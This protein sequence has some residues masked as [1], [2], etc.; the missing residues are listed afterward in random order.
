[1]TDASLEARWL[2]ERSAAV[3]CIFVFVSDSFGGWGATCSYS[4]VCLPKSREGRTLSVAAHGAGYGGGGEK[5]KLVQIVRKCN[6]Y[7]INDRTK[8]TP[9]LLMYA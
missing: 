2:T 9:L 4:F 7:R 5:G 6:E 1:M 8:L 3:G